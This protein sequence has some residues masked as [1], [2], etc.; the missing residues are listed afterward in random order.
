MRRA[1]PKRNGTRCA[2]HVLLDRD[3]LQATG[4]ARAH[5]RR[6]AGCRSGQP[7]SGPRRTRTI[8]IDG[9]RRVI[10]ESGGRGRRTRTARGIARPCRRR[11]RSRHHFR[12]SS[13]DRPSRVALVRHRPN[14]ADAQ[15]RLRWRTRFL[16]Q[17]PRPDATTR[18]NYPNSASRCRA[19]HGTV[20]RRPQHSIRTGQLRG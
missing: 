11:S 14:K 5:V 1:L 16:R 12:L 9:R 6:M 13:V 3:A 17:I 10:D 18:S 4:E 19:Q 8:C 2:R 7:R 15:T 20:Q